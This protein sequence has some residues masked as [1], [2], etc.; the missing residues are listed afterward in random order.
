MLICQRPPPH[1]WGGPWAKETI[2]SH[3]GAAAFPSSLQ[4]VVWQIGCSVGGMVAP[5][6]E[7]KRK[8]KRGPCTK[9]C[10]GEEGSW[11]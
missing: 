4:R 2:L 8:G 6:E 7:T 3:H 11:L 5:R 10:I 9:P 1:Q